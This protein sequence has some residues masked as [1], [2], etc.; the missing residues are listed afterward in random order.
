MADSPGTS[1]TLR[2]AGLH[3]D[4]AVEFR[5]LQGLTGFDSIAEEWASLAAGR[6]DLRFFQL[7]GWHRSY[8]ATL[9]PDADAV[10]FIAIYRAQRLS[11]VLPLRRRIKRMAGVRVRI[12]ELLIGPH[13][14]LADWILPAGPEAARLVSLAIGWLRKEGKPG[15][16]LLRLHRISLG[17][18]IDAALAG[19]PPP[20][21]LPDADSVSALIRIDRPAAD[22][23]AG[24]AGSFRRNLRRLT[25]RAETEAPLAFE[26]HS[27]PDSLPVALERFLDVEA[28]G[29][30]GTCGTST[31]IRCEP[32]GVAFYRRLVAEFG[33]QGQCII[34]L[35]RHGQQDVAGQFC[36]LIN[37]VLNVL[38]IGYREASSAI[39]PGNLLMERTIETSCADPGISAVSLVTNPS[40][41]PQW[42]PEAVPLRTYRVFNS[43]L[44]GLVM[45]A[46]FRVMRSGSQARA[47]LN[48][49]RA[50]APKAPRLRW[51]LLPK[52]TP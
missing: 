33:G 10:Y 46:A 47:W 18:P 22:A 49:R 36:L 23:M 40:W 3:R 34:K 13:L 39:A 24:I 28:S 9:A 2:D 19:Q 52:M 5:L 31:A 44:R 43:N 21:L 25:R 14:Y 50:G 7:P 17:S 16:D 26:S 38:K 32:G 12:L 37:G 41:S 42:N 29:W 48:G 27:S 15:W 1:S 6:R 8:L 11:A 45:Y 20:L 35:L 30:K 51:P 4:S